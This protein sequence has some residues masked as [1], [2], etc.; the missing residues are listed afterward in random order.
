LAQATGVLAGNHSQAGNVPMSQLLARI[1][2]APDAHVWRL[3]Q[4]AR[5]VLLVSA[6]YYAGGIVGI[7]LGFPPSGIASIWPPTA[8]LLAAMLLTPPRYWWI[9]LLGVVPTHLHIVDTFQR[10][11]VPFLVAVYQVTT[12]FGLAVFAALAVRSVIGAPPRF[13]SLRNMAA[14]I[15]LAGIAT[16]VIVCALAVWLFWL[17]G[18]A[19][20]FWL[21][22]RQRV[23][24]HV[25]PMITIPPVILLTV[26]GQLLGVQHA[27]K[28]AYIEFFLLTIGLLAMS[29]PV[30]GWEH[31]IPGY[32]PALL[33]APLPFLLWAAVRF[34]VGG[35][36]L[37]LLIL[38]GIALASAF[39]G[40][41]PF[42]IQSPEVLSLQIFLIAISIPLLLLAA[43]V[44]ERRRAEE[45]LK[46]TE[47]RMAVAAASTDTGLWQYDL[48]MGHLWATE[49]CRSM[50]G[51][52]ANTPLTPEAFLG[53]VHPDDRAAASAAMRA[54]ASAAETAR[55]IEFRVNHPS[56]QRWYLA[57]ANTEFDAHGE[58]IRVSGIFRD[59]TPRRKAE[60]EAEQ[61][62]DALRAT[63]REL[64][65]VS[66]QT[67]IGAMAASIAHEINQP[68]TAIVANANAGL[69]LLARGDSSEVQAALRRI[70]GDGLRAGQAVAGVRA[71][72]G[73]EGRKKS[74][75]S[76][77][78][79][80][81]EVLA[82]AGGELESQRV[83]LQVE[84]HRDL[85]RVTADRVQLQQVLLNLIMNA[86][87]AM[88]SVANRERSL[89]VKSEL[90]GARDLLIAVEDS[91][92][93]INP[94][95]M[96][97]IFDAFFTTKSHGMGLGLSICKS[98]IESH[99]GRLWAST[100]NPHGSVFYI[101][102]PCEV[103]NSPP[104]P[105]TGGRDVRLKKAS[106]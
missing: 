65:R 90:H 89:L 94:N 86:V 101:Q 102:L 57:T 55:R 4:I 62:E 7:L 43:L 9:Y 46:Q 31:P 50:F 45:S 56:G 27:P 37:S 23:A 95:D 17:T 88:S 44:E 15:F 71:I 63:R 61:L 92:P 91:G 13:D 40:R 3:P 10:P 81:R 25:F 80:V 14:F 79:L 103:P 30:F 69:R 82:L 83:S 76:I 77:N 70:V 49:H 60:Q 22:F 26:A 51:L 32:V 78:E 105:T 52:D 2:L 74:S 48:P 21:A 38:A 98:I 6:G 24:G 53:A 85:P 84:L 73:K 42:V 72:F 96:D 87:E 28:R 93:G 104:S 11:E 18:W 8:I 29:I 20:D 58:P 19:T 36:S 106:R 39:V 47:A 59:I 100:R 67:T 41:G 35:L 12:N 66:R 64:A 99:G 16:T 97:R 1:G 34:G 5:N 75:V 54:A 33:L 68:L